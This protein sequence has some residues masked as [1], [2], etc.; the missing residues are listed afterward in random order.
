MIYSDKVNS[1]E[2][3]DLTKSTNNR[4][5]IVIYAA[6]GILIMRLNFKNLCAVVVMI[7]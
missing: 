4:E 7:W 1:S 2:G 6:I 5:C 3:I